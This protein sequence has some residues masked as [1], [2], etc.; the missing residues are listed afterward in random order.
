M[1]LREV[2]DPVPVHEPYGILG[3][4]ERLRTLVRDS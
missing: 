3:Q 4:H 2:R 1:L